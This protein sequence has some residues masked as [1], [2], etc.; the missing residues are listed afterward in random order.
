MRYASGRYALGH[1]DRCGFPYPLNELKKE[2]TGSK[3]CSYCYDPKHPQLKVRR[4]QADAQTLREPRPGADV[5]GHGDGI[6]AVPWTIT[7]SRPNEMI[8][9]NF[10]VPVIGGGTSGPGG[11]PGGS[12]ATS[13]TFNWD[14]GT[15]WDQAGK[16]W[17]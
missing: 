3:V 15:H 4:H 5:D 14:D 7:M 13:S 2:W 11:T 17:S 6:P 10:I 9:A 16:V 12:P 8:Q 1:C